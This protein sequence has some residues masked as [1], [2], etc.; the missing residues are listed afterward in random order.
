MNIANTSREDNQKTMVYDCNLFFTQYL[1]D[2]TPFASHIWDLNSILPLKGFELGLSASL[3]NSQI[4]TF[5]SILCWMISVYQMDA[6]YK[7]LSLEQELEDPGNLFSNMIIL[8]IGPSHHLFICLFKHFV[9]KLNSTAKGT[10]T[11]ASLY[12][13]TGNILFQ[14]FL[15]IQQNQPKTMKYYIGINT[16]KSAHVSQHL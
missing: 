12:I 16:H 13:C 14:N 15:L 3:E 11:Y 9:Q 4:I 8:A 1:C 2:Q 7:M 5:Q 6:L 10:E